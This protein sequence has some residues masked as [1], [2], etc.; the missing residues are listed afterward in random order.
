MRR[1]RISVSGGYHR[2][3]CVI[4]HTGRRSIDYAGNVTYIASDGIV[5]YSDAAT[6]GAPVTFIKT[7][8]SDVRVP[9]ACGGNAVSAVFCG[10]VRLESGRDYAVDGES[11]ILRAAWLDTLAADAYTLDIS[12]DPL[13]IPYV[14]QPGNVAP[15]STVLTLNVDKAAGSVTLL[16]DR[17]GFQVVTVPVFFGGHGSFS[18]LETGSPLRKWMEYFVPP[19]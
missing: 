1:C 18:S 7:G 19:V 10:N 6:Q 17:S 16:S 5:L 3:Q 14:E 4:A 15:A 13:G 9:L 2:L 11:L 8:T 12:Y